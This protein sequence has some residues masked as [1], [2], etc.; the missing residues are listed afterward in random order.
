MVALLTTVDEPPL[1]S[2][3]SHRADLVS[4]Y[5][6]LDQVCDLVGFGWDQTLAERFPEPA[7]ILLTLARAA[8]PPAPAHHPDWSFSLVS[9][10]VSD[11]STMHHRPLIRELQRLGILMNRLRDGHPERTLVNVERSIR[12]LRQS[13]RQHVR[14]DEIVVFPHCLQIEEA[15]HGR[16]SWN[17]VDITGAIRIMA[18]GHAAIDREVM[19]AIASVREAIAACPDPDLQL[20]LSGLEAMKVNMDMH[21]YGELEILLPAA[22]SAEEQ[23]TARK[24]A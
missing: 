1:F 10:L 5:P 4:A 17:A 15:L 16:R 2:G 9:E 8:H 23:L 3:S 18:E 19:H 20:V 13:V 24:R 22:I 6:E 21:A 14:H 12:T 7:G 11:L